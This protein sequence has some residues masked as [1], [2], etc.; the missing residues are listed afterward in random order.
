MH[1]H[2]HPST[3]VYKYGEVQ[4]CGLLWRETLNYAVLYRYVEN[5][6]K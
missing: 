2:I 1:T 5:V 3:H 6:E 4:I